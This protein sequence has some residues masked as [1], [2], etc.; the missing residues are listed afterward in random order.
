V[1]AL[2][3][4]LDDGEDFGVNMLKSLAAL[5]RLMLAG[6]MSPYSASSSISCFLSCA[7]GWASLQPLVDPHVHA[8]GHRTHVNCRAGTRTST[9]RFSC[10][11]SIQLILTSLMGFTHFFAFSNLSVFICH[12]LGDVSELTVGPRHVEEFLV[13]QL[14]LILLLASPSD[15]NYTLL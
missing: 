6:M 1:S 8:I 9:H 12:P 15:T 4:Q 2:Q 10:T 5:Q 3:S 7:Y 14:S 11:S 13:C